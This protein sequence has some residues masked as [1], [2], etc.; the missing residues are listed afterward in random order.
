[1][2][3]SIGLFAQ[4]E[5]DVKLEAPESVVA[6]EDFEVTITFNKGE[7]KDYSRFSQDI[8]SGFTATNISSPNA[9]FTFTDQRVRIIW[10]KLPATEEV[11]VKYAIRPHER[12]AGTVELDGTFAFVNNGER[13][14][15]SLSEPTVVQVTPNPN[16]DPNMVVAIEDFNSINRP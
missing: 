16:V 8:P 9:D 3:F 4:T 11:V 12:I 15:I 7:L 1:M 14:Y 13:A 5:V 10:L 6:G 2:L